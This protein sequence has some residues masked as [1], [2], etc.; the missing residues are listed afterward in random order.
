MN[1]KAM[2]VNING[3]Y[4]LGLMQINSFWLKSLALDKEKLM[5]DACYN[6]TAGARI[7]KKCIDRFGFDW[8]AVGCYNASSLQKKINYSWK[9][10]RALSG[11]PAQSALRTDGRREPSSSLSFEVIDAAGDWSGQ[12]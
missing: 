2:N 11:K 8:E 12:Q 3:S 6:V 1:P 10:F 4:D 5:T 9:V 7:L